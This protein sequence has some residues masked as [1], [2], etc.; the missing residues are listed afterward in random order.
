MPAPDHLDP[1]LSE[2]EREDRRDRLR[3]QFADLP[4]E[5]TD[6][7]LDNYIDAAH[8]LAEPRPRVEDPGDVAVSRVTPGDVED[9]LAFFDHDA[10]TDKPE[11]AECY[12]RF[13]HTPPDDWEGRSWRDNRSDLAAGLLSGEMRAFVA[14]ADGRVVAWLNCSDRATGSRL[15]TG[16]NAGIACTFCWTVNPSYRGH[17]L[18]R[19]LLETALDE[20]ADEGVE[21]VE[22]YPADRPESDA[23]AYAGPLSLYLSCGFEGAEEGRVQRRL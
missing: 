21:V 16:D 6:T 1:Q 7:D 14:R 19:A 5:L 10:F 18:A 9:V 17:G 20:L 2:S 4:F 3:A 23:A 22:G 12:C 15:S 11:W 13:H 8:R